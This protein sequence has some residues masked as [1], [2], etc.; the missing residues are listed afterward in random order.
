MADGSISDGQ[1]AAIVTA[2]G[3]VLTGLGV[4]VRWSA[5][6]IRDAFKETREAMAAARAESSQ[7]IRDNTAAF[8][9][10]TEWLGRVDVRTEETTRRVVEVHQEISGVHEAPSAEEIAASRDSE[11]QDETP[12][13]NPM[14]R[15]NRAQSPAKGAGYSFAKAK[16]Q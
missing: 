8:A 3:A 9:K 13:E 2:L 10:F 6:I 7:V 4:A 14:R 15:H 5:G 1:L 11:E 16:K 12:V